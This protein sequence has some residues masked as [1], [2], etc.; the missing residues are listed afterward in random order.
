[1]DT[2]QGNSV[3]SGAQPYRYTPPPTHEPDPAPPAGS[4]GAGRT[5]CEQFST[6]DANGQAELVQQMLEEMHQTGWGVDVVLPNVRAMCA[7]YPSNTPI[8]VTMTG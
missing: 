6:K 1:V 8:S 7:I 5:T 4:S 3:S 2:S